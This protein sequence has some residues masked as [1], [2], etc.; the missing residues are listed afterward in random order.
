M[1]LEVIG[2]TLLILGGIIFFMILFDM[3]KLNKLRRH[4]ND[5]KD[6]SKKGELYAGEARAKRTPFE[7][8]SLRE[9]QQGDEG[10]SDGVTRL[11]ESERRE[12]LSTADTSPTRE[13]RKCKRKTGK[14]PRGILGRIRR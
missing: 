8:R 7:D 13:N 6:L 11:T 14:S 4:Y 5:E 10:R 2:L 3:R 1:F 9:E 12:L